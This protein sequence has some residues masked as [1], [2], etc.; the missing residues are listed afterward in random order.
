VETQKRSNCRWIVFGGPDEADVAQQICEGIARGRQGAGAEPLNVAGKSSLRDLC[1]LLKLCRVVLTNDSGPM[2][3]AVARKIPTVAIFCATT[4]ELGFFPYTNKAI[5]LG[6]NLSC[7][8][9]GT[10]GG[11]RCPLGHAHC[12]EQIQAKTVAEAA[13]RLLS[14]SE[15]EDRLDSFQPEF[16]TV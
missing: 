13:E 7:R 16:V 2:H 5:V 9:C 15:R 3:V 6:R 14:N 1:V 4:P 10:H 12:I 11:R 8:P